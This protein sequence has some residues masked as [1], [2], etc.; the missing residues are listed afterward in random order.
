MANGV[1][2]I[3]M[4]QEYVTTDITLRAMAEKYGIHRNTISHHM[5]MENWYAERCAHRNRLVSQ[6]VEQ[7][8]KEALKSRDLLY[9]L[10]R[11]VAGQLQSLTEEKSIGQLAEIGLKPRDI[12]GAIKDLGDALHLKSEK[13][14]E[15]QRMRIEKMRKEIDRA[16]EDKTIRVVIGEEGED[17]SG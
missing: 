3:A 6:K 13:D 16:D 7:S 9:S 12:T 5:K 1:D 15:E 8:E 4:K 2:W 10:A 14:L 11:K 17:Y